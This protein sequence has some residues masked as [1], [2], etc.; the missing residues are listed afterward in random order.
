MEHYFIFKFA[1]IYHLWKLPLKFL[2]A[3]KVPLLA[4]PLPTNMEQK[5][6]KSTFPATATGS[7]N[8]HLKNPSVG[9]EY[10]LSVLS[11]LHMPHAFPLDQK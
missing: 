9:R 8:P 5:S 7:F 2:L 3:L 11:T 10:S 6:E 1:Y 4:K